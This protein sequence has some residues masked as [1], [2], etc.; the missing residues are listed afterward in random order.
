MTKWRRRRVSL[1]LMVLILLT[2][3]VSAEAS[4]RGVFYR[5]AL[6]FVTRNAPDDL[7]L[8]VDLEREGETVP[9]YLYR[10]DRLWES[11]FRLYRQTTQGIIWYGNRVDFKGAVLVAE[12]GGI[13]TRIPLPEET[14]QKLTNSDFFMLD[15]AEYTLRFGLPIGREIPLFLLRLAI[16]VSAAMLV[17]LFYD[18]RWLKSY[19]AAL[20]VNLLC[21]AGISLFVANWINYNPKLLAVHFVVLVGVLTVQI[22]V[23]WALLDEN[24]SDKRIGYTVLSNVVTGVLNIVFLIYFPL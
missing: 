5:P 9:V 15:T 17:F 16:T 23:F 3:P 14:L 1:F 8:H 21:Q 4:G 13:E 18:F 24:E 11:Y 19:L 2:V 12:T 22:P 6:T 10:E 7:L 20:I